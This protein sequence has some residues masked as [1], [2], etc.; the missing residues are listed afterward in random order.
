M[1]VPAR[2]ALLAVLSGCLMHAG[3][4]GLPQQDL[5]RTL[6]AVG[7]GLLEVQIAATPLQ[8]QIGLMYRREMAENEGMLFVYE[9][10]AVRCFWMR[11]TPLPLTAAFI[12]A[13][14]LLVNLADMQPFTEESH[15]SARPVRFVLEV[16][17]G[18]FHRQHMGAGARFDGLYPSAD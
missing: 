2:I 9:D 16:Q 13:D 10:E 14:G 3:A 8:R 12:D 6:L 17:Q 4:S 15:C 1:P 11:D 5:P 7:Q 18:W